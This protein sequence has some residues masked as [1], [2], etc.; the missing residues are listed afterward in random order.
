MGDQV[1]G[2]H[3]V[4]VG[5]QATK[6]FQRFGIHHRA[7]GR[8]QLAF[9]Q[10]LGVR[11]AHGAHGV[12]AQAKTARKQCADGRKVKQAA[13]HFGIV[14]HGVDHHN[15][16]AFQAAVPSASSA[17]SGVSAVC[18]WLSCKVRA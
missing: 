15:L 1:F 10:R 11:A 16:G 13:H 7:C 2:V 17:T 4:G 8:A 18:N 14:T 12:I 3:R 9:E 5:V 6:V